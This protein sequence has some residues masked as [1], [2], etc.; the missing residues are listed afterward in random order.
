MKRVIE[1]DVGLV[2]SRFKGG[3]GGCCFRLTVEGAR[4]DEDEVECVR[5]L[6]YNSILELLTIGF[7]CIV[8][9]D[10]AVEQQWHRLKIF[11]VGVVVL[12]ESMDEWWRDNT[13]VW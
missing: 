12:I 5:F 10:V 4:D 8:M 2:F 6:L 13:G 3:I 11:I 9:A 7:E 1:L